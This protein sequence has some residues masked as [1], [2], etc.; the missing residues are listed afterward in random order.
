MQKLGARYLLVRALVSRG[1]LKTRV[2]A[3]LE[4]NLV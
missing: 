3:V 1:K 4:Q 2:T